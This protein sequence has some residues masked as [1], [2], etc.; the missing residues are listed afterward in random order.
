MTKFIAL[1]LMA[2]IAVPSAAVAQSSREIRKDERKVEKQR[3]D[4]R[5][6]QDRGDRKDIREQRED[7]REAR[8]ELRE[9]RRDARRTV[10]AAPYRNWTYSTLHEGS[11]LRSKFYGQR[12]VIS[13]LSTHGL[14]RVNRNQRWIRYGDDIVLVNVR[15]GRVLQVMANRYY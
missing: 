5:D 1:S 11:R 6:A 7:L 13:D 12:Y 2:A 8:Q 10:Y 4:L 15:N 14:N 9:D 3:D